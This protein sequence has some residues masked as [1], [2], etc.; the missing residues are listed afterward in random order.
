MQI[1]LTQMSEFPGKQQLA[2]DHQFFQRRAKIELIA[3]VCSRIESEPC[4]RK[5]NLCIGHGRFIGIR[6]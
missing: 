5:K 6:D 3:F 1:A 4:L 2:K